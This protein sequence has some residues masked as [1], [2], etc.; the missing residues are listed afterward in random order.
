MRKINLKGLGASSGIAIGKVFKLDNPEIVIESRLCNVQEEL[1]RFQE[2]VNKTCENIIQIKEKANTKLSEEDLAVF[3]THLAMVR[4]PEYIEKIESEI[5]NGCSA[6]VACQSVSNMMISLFET[7]QDPYFKER[8]GEIK[9]ISYRLLCN[10]LGLEIPSLDNVQEEVV[11][12]SSELSPADTVSLNLDFV[13]GFVC[14]L[15]GKTSHSAIIA[16]SLAIPAIVGVGDVLKTLVS[17]DT[18]IVDGTSGDIIVNPDKKELA[19][20][21]EIQRQQVIEKASLQFLIDK[22]SITEDHHRIELCANIGSPKDLESVLKNGAEG[23]GLFRTEFLY[24]EKTNDF[25]SEEEQFIAYKSVL[26]AMQDKKVVVRTLDIGGDKKLPYFEFEKEMNPFLGY[27]A[28]RLCLDRKDIFKTQ[29]RALLRASIYGK[30]CIMFPMIATVNEFIEAKDFVL[31]TKQELVNEGE[32]VSENIEIGMM[33]ELPSA[34]VL[35]NEFARY[36]DFFSIGTND[37]LQYT[38]AADRMSEKVSYL[39]Q[40]LNPSILRLIKMTIDGAHSAK[41]WCGLCGEMASDVLSAPLLLGLGLDEFSMSPISILP[42]RKQIRS[43][44]Y[45]KMKEMANIACKLATQEEV[46]QLIQAYLS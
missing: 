26:E 7:M 8:S 15:G 29:I 38:M 2:A 14:E 28:I 30:L 40:P 37:L 35:A 34:A 36:A 31:A 32:P 1:H 11:V 3:D 45:K 18:I 27:R 6:E 13:K 17:G 16:R 41:K 44:S 24:M 46:E 9:D 10:I 19:F 22:Q 4:D 5:Q 25:P 42:A 21:Q 12:V 20:Y 33:V 43:M 23:I 39:Y